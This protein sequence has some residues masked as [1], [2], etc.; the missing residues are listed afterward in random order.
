[1]GEVGV[2]PRDGEVEC[3][4]DVKGVACGGSLGY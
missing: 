1:M 3:E 4:C 2:G